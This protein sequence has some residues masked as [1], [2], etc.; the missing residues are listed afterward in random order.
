[1]NRNIFLLLIF[2]LIVRLYFV[3]IYPQ[4]PVLADAKRYD[5]LGWN[6]A[7]GNGFVNETGESELGRGPGY[8]F[9]L[10]VIYK[11]FGHSYHY[12]R[13]FQVLF[14]MCTLLLIF[15]LAKDAFGKN[16]AFLSLIIASFYPPFL[17]YSGIL[18]AET[19]FTFFIVLSS[20]LLL[21]GIR[22]KKWWI[23]ILLGV[24]SGCAVLVRSEFILLFLCFFALTIIYSRENLNKFIYAA[25]IAALVI[26]PWTIRNYKVSGRF[27]LVS[28]LFG[29]MLWISTYEGEWLEWHNNDPH[30]AGLIKGLDEVEKDKVLWAEGIKNIKENPFQYLKFCFK[31]LG[32]F[33]IGGHSNTFYGLRD[34]LSSYFSV[35]AYGKVVIKVMF[36]IFNTAL[37]VLGG[38]GILAAIRTLRNKKRE[39]MFLISPIFIVM[40]L[41]TLLFGTARYQVPI[42]PLIII[43]AAFGVLFLQQEKIIIS[44][45]PI[46]GA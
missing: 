17:S 22:Q 1:M 9:F 19:L 8:P 5:V 23:Y 42:M 15:L 11:V 3:F 39:L 30:Y 44:S 16:T 40:L 12:A 31:Y 45:K 27:V 35:K 6:L 32:R 7:S 26:A 43:F 29:S 18:Y 33:W 13:F 37:I 2:A 20:Y 34:S 41:H 46:R 21:L 25:L 10:A 14:S 38:C 4:F 28:S 36:L 24:A